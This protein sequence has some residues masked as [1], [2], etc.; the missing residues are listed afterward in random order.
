VKECNK[1]DTV[2]QA[3]FPSAFSR[4]AASVTTAL[5][6]RHM[7]HFHPPPLHSVTL[8]VTLPEPCKPFQTL[9]S[10]RNV[11]LSREK[12]TIPLY[13]RFSV[14]TAARRVSDSLPPCCLASR[15]LG[16]VPERAALKPRCTAFAGKSPVTAPAETQRSGFGGKRKKRGASELSRFRA[17]ANDTEPLLTRASIA[18]VCTSALG[19][20]TDK[21]LRGPCPHPLWGAAPN[22]AT[23]KSRRKKEDIHEQGYRFQ[24]PHFQ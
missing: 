21:C 8:H 23:T 4:A 13:D 22:P 2:P 17:E 5:Q 12:K 10:R 15:A 11:T 20:R 18:F 14:L 7:L 9:A 1:C 6:K 19:R 16:C 3:L 24:H